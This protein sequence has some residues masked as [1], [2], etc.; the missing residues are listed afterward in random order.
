MILEAAIIDRM[1]RIER[2]LT[3]IADALDRAIPPVNDT[4]SRTPSEDDA[5]VFTVTPEQQAA[6]ELEEQ[7]K[8]SGNAPQTEQEAEPK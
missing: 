6:W 1:E 7:M 4:S 5:D 3:R 8:I 2:Q